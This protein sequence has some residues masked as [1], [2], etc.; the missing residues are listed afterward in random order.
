M[1]KELDFFR[2]KTHNPPQFCH[3][4]LFHVLHSSFCLSWFLGGSYVVANG[5]KMYEHQFYE[6][7]IPKN[8]SLQ[9]ICHPVW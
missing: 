3:G 6:L 5:R 2:M 1:K 7:K 4:R 9:N 8:S